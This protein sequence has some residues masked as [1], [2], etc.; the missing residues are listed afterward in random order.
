LFFHE[1]YSSSKHD[2]CVGI[3][4]QNPA[5]IFTQTFQF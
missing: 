4:Q 1:N 3:K 5:I 2:S